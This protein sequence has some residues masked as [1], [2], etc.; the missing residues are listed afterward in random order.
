MQLLGTHGVRSTRANDDA[1]KRAEVLR[2]EMARAKHALTT[3]ASYDQRVE[4]TRDHARLARQMHVQAV[5][6]LPTGAGCG[7]LLTKSLVSNVRDNPLVAAEDGDAASWQVPGRGRYDSARDAGGTVLEAEHDQA[8]AM[9]AGAAGVQ[10][11]GVPGAAELRVSRLESLTIRELLDIKNKFDYRPRGLDLRA[12]CDAFAA[13]GPD[14]LQGAVRLFLAMDTS[15]IGAVSWDGF[16]S[17]MVQH[18][19]QAVQLREEHRRKNYSILEAPPVGPPPVLA[20][21][22]PVPL[23]SVA[24]MAGSKYLLSTSRDGTLAWWD[25]GSLHPVRTI[26]AETL[27][28]ADGRRGRHWPLATALVHRDCLDRASLLIGSTDRSVLLYDVHSHDPSKYELRGR[29][30]L[31]AVPLAM[32]HWEGPS[33]AAWLS[34]G[35]ERGRVLTYDTARLTKL[36]RE[37]HPAPPFPRPTLSPEPTSSFLGLHTDW[38]SAVR[39]VPH[40]QSGALVTASLDATLKILDVEQGVVKS[41]L[42]GHSHGVHCFQPLDGPQV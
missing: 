11:T 17:Y 16:L 39:W 36:A 7:S 23:S 32:A 3:A 22:H 27:G 31:G 21:R 1:A 37:S 13:D 38:V 28:V 40:L 12:F 20:L 4:A 2:R 33:G 14:A 41:T 15:G 30:P 34:V 24:R 9:E 8:A 42:A 5:L 18:S 6:A 10:S 26:R 35:D 25:A 19:A 29:A